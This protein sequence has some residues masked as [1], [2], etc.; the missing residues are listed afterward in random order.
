MNE[1]DALKP[2]VEYDRLDDR[3]LELVKAESKLRNSARS[4]ASVAPSE[5]R[6]DAPWP[7]LHEQ[8]RHARAA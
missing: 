1:G 5:R 2:D 3:L 4:C 7:H 6:F 8:T